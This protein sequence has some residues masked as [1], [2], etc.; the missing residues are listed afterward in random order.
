MRDEATVSEEL[1]KRLSPLI[2]ARERRLRHPGRLPVDDR[3]ALEGILWVLRHD[4]PRR[5]LPT[6]L[7]E[8]SGMTCWR[9]LGTGPKP[10]LVRCRPGSGCCG[11]SIRRGSGR[12]SPRR[13]RLLL[14]R[15]LNPPNKAG[16]SMSAGFK[17]LAAVRAA[18]PS[19]M[20][21]EDVRT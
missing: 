5:E 3:E 16:W 17:L 7:F 1:W 6:T 19:T 15:R 20:S 14:V 21:T 13:W 9:R 4:V 2:P 18:V 12:P 10:G 8:V 11:R